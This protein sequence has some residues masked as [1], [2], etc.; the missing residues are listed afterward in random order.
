MYVSMGHVDTRDEVYLC[1]FSAC[2]AKE[3]SMKVTVVCQRK[4][5]SGRSIDILIFLSC[6]GGFVSFSIMTERHQKFTCI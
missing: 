2:V 3:S 4:S 6:L 1:M 5:V